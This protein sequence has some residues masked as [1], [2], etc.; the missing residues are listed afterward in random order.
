MFDILNAPLPPSFWVWFALARFAQFCALCY[1]TQGL[2]RHRV[3][4]LALLPF[5]GSL[6]YFGTQLFLT[7]HNYPSGTPGLLLINIFSAAGY[8][9]IGHLLDKLLIRVHNARVERLLIKLIGFLKER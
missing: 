2:L 1:V 8:F 6:S 5:L 3:H 7:Q 9:V 4:I